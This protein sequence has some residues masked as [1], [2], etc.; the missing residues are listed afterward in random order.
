MS[1]AV[2]EYRIE[3]VRDFRVVPPSRRAECLR[4]FGIWLDMA[5][6]QQRLLAAIGESVPGADGVRWE[7]DPAFVWIDDGMGEMRMTVT[8]GEESA[9]IVTSTLR[10]HDPGADREPR[11]PRRVRRVRALPRPHMEGPQGRQ[12]LQLQKGA[13]QAGIPGTP[14]ATPETR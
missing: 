2:N 8:A 10:R 13:E 7:L 14:A 4:E 6:R 1:E 9:T 12:V 5:E 11:N 3:S